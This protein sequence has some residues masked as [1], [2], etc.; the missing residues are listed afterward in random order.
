MLVSDEYTQQVSLTQGTAQSWTLP[1]GPPG[2]TI[3][4]RGWVS[5]WTPSPGD[6]GQLVDFTVRAENAAGSDEQSWQVL[7]STPPPCEPQM[8]SDFETYADGTRVLF[9]RPSYSGS[10]YEDL[11]PA[12]D[13]AEVTTEVA[14]FGG[15]GCYHVAWQFVD[16]EPQRWMR[17][18]THEV[19]HL[20]NPTLRLDHVIR[21][22]LRVDAGRF[23]LAVGVRETGTTAD[24]GDDG[25]TGG[26]IEWIGAAS[27]IDGRAAGRARRAAARRVADVQL[28]SA[29][30][31]DPR[32]DRRRYARDPVEQGHARAPGVRRG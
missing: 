22:R 32:H 7:V 18:T 15:G 17:L 6:D 30:R 28:R 31:P 19:P 29:N 5:G 24:I 20:P 27:G 16:T 23:R 14:G 25:G 9:Q 21:V 4:A 8:L 3:S 11:E 1:I 12:P 26:A 2:A 10:T 13:V